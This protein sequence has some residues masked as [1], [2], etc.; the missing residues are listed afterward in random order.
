MFVGNTNVPALDQILDGMYESNANKI[1]NIWNSR[2]KIGRY[3][4]SRNKEYP[5]G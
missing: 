4:K 2:N 1:K 3:P 5:I